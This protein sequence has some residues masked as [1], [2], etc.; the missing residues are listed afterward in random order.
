MEAPLK[1]GT[2]AIN[3]ECALSWDT[4]VSIP[5]P[6]I[7]FVL[8]SLPCTHVQGV[9][10]SVLSLLSSSTQNCQILRSRH[11]SEWP[12]FSRCQKWWKSYESFLLRKCLART[13]NATYRAITVCNFHCAYLSSIQVRVVKSCWSTAE[14]TPHHTTTV[15]W[16][17]WVCT[18]QSS[19][20]HCH[21]YPHKKCQILIPRCHSE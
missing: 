2:W 1:F 6:T 17:C 3:R 14:A 19:S 8:L 16:Q 4:M 9:K 11:L 5:S 12:T 18:L 20:Y 21:I 7:G 10:L 15:Q 13:M